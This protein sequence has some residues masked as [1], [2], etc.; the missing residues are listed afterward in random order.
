MAMTE[1]ERI[2]RDICA[3]AVNQGGI[4]TDADQVVGILMTALTKAPPGWK[5]VPEALTDE[6]AIDF[7]EK[8]FSK[9]RC[10]DDPGM[11][12]AYAALLAAAPEY[13]ET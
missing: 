8:W 12:D 13:K 5:L 2:A 7:T 1:L 6:M 9:V 11:D 4:P 10:I 3:E